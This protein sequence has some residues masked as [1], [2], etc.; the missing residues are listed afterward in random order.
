MKPCWGKEET[1]CNIYCFFNLMKR[2]SDLLNTTRALIENNPSPSYVLM[3]QIDHL[4]YYL[5]K[6]NIKNELEKSLDFCWRNIFQFFY[7]CLDLSWYFGL[8]RNLFFI[9]EYKNL[10]IVLIQ[11]CMCACKSQNSVKYCPSDSHIR[12][13][14]LTFFFNFFIVIDYF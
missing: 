9:T 8:T 3:T 12:C 10:S 6:L 7:C 1:K 14:F 13:S 2:R 5:W 4:I 11:I